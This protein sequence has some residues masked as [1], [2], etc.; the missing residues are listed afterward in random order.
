MSS[1][2]GLKIILGEDVQGY[3]V[4]REDK[5]YRFPSL[6]G[7]T[8][9]TYICI[10]PWVLFSPVFEKVITCHLVQSAGTSLVLHKFLKI[11]A[12]SS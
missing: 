10:I 3:S 8:I 2:R 1:L 6:R 4:V 7:Q 11:I 5:A 12:N 9:Y